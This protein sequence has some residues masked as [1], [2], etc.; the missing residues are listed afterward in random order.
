MK[1]DICLTW[2]LQFYLPRQPIRKQK[3]L[4]VMM[5]IWALITDENY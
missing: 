3:F 2:H 1:T 4:S 5:I